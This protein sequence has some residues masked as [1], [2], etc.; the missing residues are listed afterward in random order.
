[1]REKKLYIFDPTVPLIA[2]SFPSSPLN[3]TWVLHSLEH[4]SLTVSLFHK[5]LKVLFQ[6]YVP[7]ELIKLQIGNLQPVI[8]FLGYL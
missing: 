1:M 4:F 8:G 5:C 7:H 3:L 6:I 2:P